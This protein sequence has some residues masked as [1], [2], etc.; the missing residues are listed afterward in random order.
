MG[1]IFKA[2]SLLCPRPTS[3]PATSSLQPV[4][5]AEQPIVIDD[6]DDDDDDDAPMRVHRIRHCGPKGHHWDGNREETLAEGTT[7]TRPR[8]VLK[9]APSAPPRA[10]P[11][12]EQYVV[13]RGPSVALLFGMADFLMII[14]SLASSIASSPATTLAPATPTSKALPGPLPSAAPTSKQMGPP[15]A[16]SATPK[17]KPPS[18]EQV[19]IEVDN[20]FLEAQ[21]KRNK[22]TTEERQLHDAMLAGHLQ[23]HA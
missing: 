13:P 12:V 18:K 7:V 2:L 4:A 22:R 19:Q 3:G 23:G 8:A 17:P 21:E 1:N 16:A 20:T 9:S 14:P 6:D 15:P 11:S 5:E 10:P